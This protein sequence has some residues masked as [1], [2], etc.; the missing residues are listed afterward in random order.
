MGR[1]R[2]LIPASGRGGSLTRAL[3]GLGLGA[4]TLATPARADEPY[5]INAIL[6]LTGQASF[7]GKEEQVSLQ[8]AEKYVN[9]TGGMNT[10]SRP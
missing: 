1:R 8:I 3:L 9:R 4:A 7:L 6:P 2:S 10:C 5:K